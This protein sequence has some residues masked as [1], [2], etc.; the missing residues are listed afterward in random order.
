VLEHYRESSQYAAEGLKIAHQYEDK[1]MIANYEHLLKVLK[2]KLAKKQ[3]R[4]L[5]EIKKHLKG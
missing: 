3:S 2:E 4:K 5:K 1:K